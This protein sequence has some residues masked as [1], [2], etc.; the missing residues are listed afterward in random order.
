MKR[1]Y[2]VCFSSK[3]ELLFRQEEDYYSGV[4]SL[5]LSLFKTETD[6]LADSLMSNHVH[7][8]VLTKDLKAFVS[9]FRMR[10]AAYFNKKYLRSGH[11]GERGHYEV[12]IIG[13]RH[14]LAAMSYVFR[15]GFHHGLSSLP[16]GY[17]H[18]SV[19]CIFQKDFGKM[20]KA[21]ITSRAEIKSLLPRYAEFPD[22]Y[23]MDENRMIM[24]EAFV[25]IPQVEIM[26]STPKSFL[27][28]MT[29][30]SGE[31][32]VNEQ[33]EGI[34][35]AAPI[36]LETIEYGTG[37]TIE[38]MLYYEKSKFKQPVKTDTEVCTIIDNFFLPKLKKASIYCLSE[39]EKSKIFQ[40]LKHEM[41]V[42]E[43]QAKRCLA[44]Q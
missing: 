35:A 40:T 28:N 34:K 11:L 18:S 14:Q 30:P 27:Y 26:Y 7:L 39:S 29:R 22:N 43:N 41:L 5:A 15:N 33:K 31:Q 42:K 36:T 6:L 1:L 9:N 44:I 25:Q 20:K 13:I 2:H 10:Y 23:V 19:G 3:N 21:M 37:G 38:K 16:F 4:N 17:P 8:I 24:R 12:E 32:W